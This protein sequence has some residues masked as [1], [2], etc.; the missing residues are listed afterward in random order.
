L[1]LESRIRY[2]EEQHRRLD[3]ATSQ[4]E[5]KRDVDR[6]DKTKLDLVELKKKKLAV[7]DELAALRKELYENQFE[8]NFS[9]YD[10]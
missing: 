10:R 9:D 1:D 3:L 4:L 7:R 8:L 6:S 2:L 5:T